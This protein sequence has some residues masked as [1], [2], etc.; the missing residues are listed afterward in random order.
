M[1]TESV[2]GFKDYTGE[3]A[4]KRAEIKKIIQK[5]FE[6]SGF[7]P[8]E[9]PIIEY[10]EF[11]KSDNSNDEAV[12]EIFKLQDR[13]KRKLAL[14]YEF[15]FQLKRLA[16]NQKLPYK[17]YQLGP[18]FRDEPISSN[19]FRQ[20][21]QCDID[22]I[23]STIKDE[24]EILSI[25]SNI[26]SQ[27][28]I[29]FTIN[30]NNRKL[31]NEILEEQKVKEKDKEAV[32]RE[33]DK[34]DKLPE[35]NVKENLKKYKAEKILLIFKKQESYFKKYKSYQEIQELKKYCSLYKIKINF[36]PSL[37]RGLSYYNGSIF[38]IKSNI[39]ESIAAGGSY[40]I[41]N[42]QSTGISFG[43]ERLSTLAKVEQEK[44]KYL[45]ISINQDKKAIELA[46]KLRKN[47]KSVIIMYN[48]VSKALEYANS[49]KIHYVIFIG[50][51]EVKKKKVKLR[52]MATGKEK[53]ISENQV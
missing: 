30:I 48:K 32:I 35:S 18:V 11:V 53:L 4:E 26:L 10:E 33:I 45:I 7:E 19:R 17:R 42:L 22:T 13:G 24:A 15:T 44:E 1:K 20:F 49:K 38:E 40:M 23:G 28:K 21:I 43:L 9:T 2:K 5:Q 50:K 36:Q 12:S 31:L 27:L 16:K 39:K 52:N 6:L 37:A 29:K 46:D 8:A 47:N 14:R 34:L 3:Q 25:V 51:E 41:N